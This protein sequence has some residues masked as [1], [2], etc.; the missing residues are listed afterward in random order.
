MLANERT[1]YFEASMPKEAYESGRQNGNL[2]DHGQVVAPEGPG[3]GIEVDWDNLA[4]ADF[5]FKFV[6]PKNT[7]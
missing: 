6:A 7:Q 2:L 4:M 1:R 3:L 5:Y